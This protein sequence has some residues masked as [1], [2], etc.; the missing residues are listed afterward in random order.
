MTR[1]TCKLCRQYKELCDSHLIPAA[2]YKYLLDRTQKNPHPIVVGRNIT[3]TTSQQ[4]TDY[5][6]CADCEDLFNKNGENWMVRQVWNGQRFPLLDR[7]NVAH[8]QYM[9]REFV[10]FSGVATGVDTDKLGYFG[11]SV[12]W[13]AAVHI[14]ATPFGGRTSRLNLGS[15]EE[16]IRSFLL[17]QSPF[18]NNICAVLATVCT[19]KASVGSFYMPSP[20]SRIPETAFSLLTLGVH[21]MVFVGSIPS[22]LRGCCCLQSAKKLIWARNCEQKTVEAFAQLM[23]TSKRAKNFPF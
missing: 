13:R 18:P 16:P 1:G 11:L 6:L 22:V 8:P 9:F 7:L 14:W 15:S 10:A 23:V 12:L 17:R 20:V 2:M 4:V 19:D 5:V 3:T 21:F